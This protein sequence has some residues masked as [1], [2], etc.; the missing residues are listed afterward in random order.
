MRAQQLRLQRHQVAVARGEVDQRLDADPLLAQ[1][2]EGDAAH[3]HPRH[4]AVADVDAVDARRFQ[5]RR[6]LQHLVRVDAARRIDLDADDELARANLA[7]QRRAVVDGRLDGGLPAS[8]RRPGAAS[9]D[10]TT[11]TPLRSWRGRTLRIA[12]ICA[13][14]VPQQPPMIATPASAKRRAYSA[15]YSG[16]DT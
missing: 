3:A 8:L 13:G 9:A 14:V 6:A 15:K 7:R 2:R 11:A 10:V 4:R 5:Q 12:A 1:R 16:V